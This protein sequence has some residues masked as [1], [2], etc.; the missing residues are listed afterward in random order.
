MK[1]RRCIFSYPLLLKLELSN[2]AIF[3]FSHYGYFRL[4]S[5]FLVDSNY[6]TY[7]IAS[8]KGIAD[9]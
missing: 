7:A 8:K 9:N 1:H 6:P 5:I 3:T 4:I 2:K